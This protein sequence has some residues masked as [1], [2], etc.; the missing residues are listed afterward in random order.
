M[1]EVHASESQRFLIRLQQRKTENRDSLACASCLYSQLCSSWKMS[2]L[3]NREL[4]KVCKPHRDGC[5]D[6]E[7]IE[8]NSPQTGNDYSTG[9][10]V[11]QSRPKNASLLCGFLPTNSTRNT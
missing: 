11:T 9:V 10:S 3:H 6:Y 2:R 1:R 8:G 7:M 4:E 5:V